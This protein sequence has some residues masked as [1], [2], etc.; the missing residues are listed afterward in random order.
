MERY[1]FG[2]CSYK[3]STI[4]ASP[5]EPTGNPNASQLHGL[6]AIR[7]IFQLNAGTRPSAVLEWLPSG[8]I[9]IYFNSVSTL[10][11]SDVILKEVCVIRAGCLSLHCKAL[12]KI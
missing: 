12:C 8:F 2:F 4:E 1:V 7:L 3:N 11:N 5:L 10:Y 6:F 9:R